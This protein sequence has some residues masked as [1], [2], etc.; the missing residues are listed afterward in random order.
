MLYLAI[1]EKML[2]PYPI[3]NHCGHIERVGR[4][5]N[6]ASLQIVDQC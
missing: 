2:S 3:T 5:T 6:A 4:L 1:M